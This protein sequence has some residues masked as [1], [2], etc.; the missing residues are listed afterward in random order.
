M[1]EKNETLSRGMFIWHRRVAAKSNSPMMTAILQARLYDRFIEINSNL[2]RKKLYRRN[3]FSNFFGG[4][5]SNRA[6]VRAPI[7]FRRAR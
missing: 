3:R 2:K 4:S 7:Q 5:F 6:N 1:L